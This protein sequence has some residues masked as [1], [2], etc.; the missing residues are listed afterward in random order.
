MSKYQILIDEDKKRAA[1]VDA[2]KSLGSTPS[3]EEG[4]AQV[5]AV[6]DK[7][8]HT[9]EVVGQIAPQHL[10]GA[11]LHAPDPPYRLPAD[12][13]RAEE[14]L[15]IE[16]PK[17]E[18]RPT[19]Y[20]LTS[21]PKDIAFARM[22]D[23]VKLRWRIERDYEELKQEVGLGHFEG[24]SWRGLHHHAALCIA[25]YGFLVSEKETIPPSAAC[26]SWRSQAPAIPE[27]YQPRGAASANPA[28]H[29]QL[30]RN[31]AMAFD[32]SSR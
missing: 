9:S 5:T 7:T 17:S 12:D 23:N 11:S 20:T 8:P 13:P 27:S 19:K 6:W 32:L 22:V 4:C 24:R 26:S 30:N 2:G 31:P 21:L 18:K 14:W 29:A 3:A 16:W 1:S 10:A 25:T 15:L 28:P